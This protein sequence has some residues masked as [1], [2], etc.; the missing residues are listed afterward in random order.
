VIDARVTDH[1]YIG[2]HWN[3]QGEACVAASR[4]YLQEGIY[5]RFENK[6]ADRMKNWVVGDPFD[7][8]VNQGPQVKIDQ[9]C[10]PCSLRSTN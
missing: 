7:P 6:L 4:V 3:L 9:A 2:L 8:R 5:D 10:I 1:S